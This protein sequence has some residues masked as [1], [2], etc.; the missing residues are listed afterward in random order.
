[1]SK[2]KQLVVQKFGGSSVADIDCLR[3][4]ASRILE[5]FHQ[6]NSVVV[7][8]SAMG[9]STDE[10]IALAC[11]IS[12][13]PSDRE[14]DMLM[15]TGEQVSAALLAM[16]LHAMGVDAVALTGPQAGIYTDSV[17]RKA[18][19]MEIDA[20]RIKQALRKNQIVVVAGFQG[21]TPAGDI[22]T[23]GRGG[24][25]TT[26]VALAAALRAARCQ[27]FTDVAGVYTT[28]PRIIKDAPKLA[29]ISYD[30][31]LE[32]AS[33]GAKVITPRAVEFAKKNNVEIEVLS[34]F[35]HEQGTVI[36]EKVTQ[37]EDIVVRG[38]SADKNQVKVTITGVPDRP[39]VAAAIFRSLA[40]AN[41]NIDMIVQNTG[42]QGL[43]DI[44]FTLSQDDEKQAQ[45][46]LQKVLKT[47]GGKNVSVNTDIA[48]VSIVGIGMRGRT[49]V[50]SR[51]F[52]E[53][54]KHKINILMIVTTEIK[55]TVVV[56]K[57]ETEKAMCLLYT[58][59][60]LDRLKVRR[61]SSE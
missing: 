25:D 21:I 19:I 28:D 60:G 14:L 31:M 33:L 42:M 2:K 4:V 57:S 58:A 35:E 47:V 20:S 24:S 54:A 27:I 7:V 55:I 16:M 3:R 40:S 56:K 52:E 53:L 32:L 9:D 45:N 30:E 38:V 15:A 46:E 11:K 37:M 8:V 34:S 43:A 26:A 12:E 6:G 49:G 1:M 41:I 48:K 39:G 36:K 29:E 23:L 18:K 22:A 5:T 51:V 59:F 10:L 44:S 17:H 61:K 50:A 13:S